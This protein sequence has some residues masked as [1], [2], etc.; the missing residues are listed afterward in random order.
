MSSKRYSVLILIVS[1]IGVLGVWF[2]SA[3]VLGEMQAEAGLS[4]SDLAWLSTATQIGFGIGALI[5][6]A[7]GLA[8]RYDPRAVFFLSACASAGANA[9]LIWMPVGGTEAVLLRGLTGAFLAGVYPVGMKIA[10]GWGKEDR[11]MLVGALVGAL[12]IGS[13]S[14]HLIALIGG[15]DWRATIMVTTAI[16]VAGAFAMLT[17]GLG[18]Y[19]AKAPRLDVTAIKLAW[20]DKR[21]RLAI[22]GYLCHM[23]ELYALWAWVGVMAAGSFAAAGVVEVGDLA[24]LTAFLAIALGGIICL[25]AGIWADRTGKARVAAL[26]LASSG[27]FGLIAAFGYGGP[28]W[29]MVPMLIV[30]GVLV[31]PDSALFSAL[32][33]DAAPPERAGSIMTLQNAIGFLLTAGTVQAAPVA[34]DAWGWPVVMA[35]IAI[36]PFAGIWC[37][38]ALQRMGTR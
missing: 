3:A 38:V 29:F 19:H 26:V 24:K 27:T 32:V 35:A 11:A 31:I 36:G 28:V 5:Y 2:S 22:L 16:A 23:W 25:P 33:A 9:L 34:A 1:Q 30:W 14:P 4:A 8:D 20:T 18:P 10:V 6:A 15:S 12:T 7:L 37:M 21:I 13:A 17:I